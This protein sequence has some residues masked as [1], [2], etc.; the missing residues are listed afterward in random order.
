MG[1]EWTGG[2]WVIRGWV[3]GWMGVSRDWWE[4]DRLL[5]GEWVGD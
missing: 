5:G 1:R 2:R 3:D 4:V